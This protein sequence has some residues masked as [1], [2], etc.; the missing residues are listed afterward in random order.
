M[1]TIKEFGVYFRSNVHFWEKNKAYYCHCI[2]KVDDLF[3]TDM[4]VWD[5]TSENQRKRIKEFINKYADRLPVSLV[6]N[7]KSRLHSIIL[8]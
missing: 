5:H 1:T 3:L 7:F 4:V 8:R 6:S 2:F